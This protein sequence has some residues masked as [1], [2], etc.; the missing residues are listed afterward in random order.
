MFKRSIIIVILMSLL[1]VTQALAGKLEGLVLYLPFDEGSGD[2]VRDGSGNG[3]DGI[4]TK[5]KWGAGKIGKALSFDGVSFVEVPSSDSLESLVEEMTVAA[6]INPK[7]TGSAWQGI[8][9]KGNDG[10]EHFE[11]LVNVDA[12]V[13]TAQM[14]GAGRLWIDRPA[15]VII[16]GEWQHLAVTYKPGEWIFY[17]N[18]EA[19]DTNTTANT[20]LV[21][22]GN[23]VVIGDE[24]PMN[25]LFEGSIDEVAIFNKAISAAEV[26]NIMGGIASILSVESNDKLATTWA[27]IKK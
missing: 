13:H 23:P 4:I 2:T 22:D 9:T 27:Y 8:V 17:H 5:A 26:E 10:A 11:V 20:P 6:W 12:H 3:N 25:R 14:F 21:P 18:G 1:I 7:L 16:K 15:G 24:R 19:L